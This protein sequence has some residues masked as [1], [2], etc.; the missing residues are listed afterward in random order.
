MIDSLILLCLCHDF[1]C[2]RKQP[3]WFENLGFLEERFSL[4]KH[5]RMKAARK[6]IEPSRLNTFSRY[7]NDVFG[8][9][10]TCALFS[11][12]SHVLAAPRG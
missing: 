5:H 12:P 11:V 4:C 8:N 1:H 3:G 6:G 9:A 7:Q 10:L 2:I